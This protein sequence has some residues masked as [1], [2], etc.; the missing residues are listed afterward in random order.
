MRLPDPAPEAAPEKA[1]GFTFYP[2]AAPNGEPEAEALAAHFVTPEP[3]FFVRSHAPPPEVDPVAFRLSV[4][5]LVER[6]LA[7]SLSDLEAFP[8]KET[9]ATLQCAG[10]RRAEMSAVR[11]VSG[12]PWQTRAL[13]TAV[14]R[15]CT[16]A[17]VLAQAGVAAGA[18]HIEFIGLDDCKTE[19]GRTPFGGSIPLAKA[20]ECD[21]LLAWE[22]NGEPLPPAHGFPLRAVVPGYLG[23]RSVKWLGRIV[24]RDTPSDNFYYADDYRLLPPDAGPTDSERGFP[25]GEMSVNA[26]IL[27]PE[28]GAR[29]AAGPVAFT[30]YATAGGTRTVERVEL[31]TDGGASWMEA[32]FLDPASPGAWRRWAAELALAPGAHV[33]AVRAWDSAANTQPER[34]EAVWNARGYMH[35]AWHRIEVT[36][37]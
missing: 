9:T 27:A 19:K 1:P 33:V 28:G 26:A 25:L 23:A 3:H 6:P 13:S 17:D 7:L 12:V 32:R 21:V 31:T 37:E 16:L 24:V 11:P 29:V 10:N 8:T 18:A 36:A 14:W 4:E 30:G 15:G 34:A 5:G 35:H 22:M 2:G 20:M